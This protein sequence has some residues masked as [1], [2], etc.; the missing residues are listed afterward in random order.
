MFRFWMMLVITSSN[1][2]PQYLGLANLP[3]VRPRT[4]TG[5]QAVSSTQVVLSHPPGDRLPLL[6]A[7]PAVT[8]PVK[9]CAHWPVPNYTA[10]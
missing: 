4:N 5:V 1:V 3:S 10:W 7:R 9:E 2:S 6:S 8:F